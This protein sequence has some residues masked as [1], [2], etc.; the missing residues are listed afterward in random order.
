MKELEHL[1]VSYAEETFEPLC[2]ANGMFPSQIAEIAFK[3]GFEKARKMC[4]ELSGVNEPWDHMD[5]VE[6][7]VLEILAV[8]ESQIE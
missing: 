2:K 5:F 7:P 3:A 1:A 6:V 8:G 4:A